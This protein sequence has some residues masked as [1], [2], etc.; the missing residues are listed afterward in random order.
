M[1]TPVSIRSQPNDP[2]STPINTHQSATT[3]RAWPRVV[4]LPAF[5]PVDLDPVC[6]PPSCTSGRF[7]R[8]GGVMGR[9]IYTNITIRGVTYADASAASVALGVQPQT[10]VK[11]LQ[12]G[13]LDTCGSGNSHPRPMRVAI[14]GKTFET[15]KEAA[16]AHGVKPSAIYTALD[17]GRIDRIGMP[18]T[19]PVPSNSKAF[20]LGPLEFES[21]RKASIALGFNPAYVSKVYLRNSAVGKERIYAAAMQ[22]A[23]DHGVKI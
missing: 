2:F 19:Q 3:L 23:Q 1:L 6:F 7:F 11:A 10:V 16:E 13:T 20:K 4:F 5:L 21:Q 9:R 22:Y 8:R 18:P 15:V 12:K 17:E 14:R